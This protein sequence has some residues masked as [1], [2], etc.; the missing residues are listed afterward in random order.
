[1]PNGRND[2][3]EHDDIWADFDCAT[4]AS[5]RKRMLSYGLS[6]I[7]FE[8]TY[9]TEDDSWQ[10]ASAVERFEPVAPGSPEQGVL[11]L[12]CSK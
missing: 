2:L 8:R 5:R 9:R 6:R 3:V 12:L 4:A 10:D 7:V 1:L 11:R